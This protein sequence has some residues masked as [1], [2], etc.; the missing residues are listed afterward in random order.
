M[1][2]AQISGLQPRKKGR[3]TIRVPG[4][5]VCE[6]LGADRSLGEDLARALPGLLER[7]EVWSNTTDEQAS[8]L[9]AVGEPSD[10]VIAAAVLGGRFAVLNPVVSLSSAAPS[11]CTRGRTRSAAQTLRPPHA[12]RGA[13]WR[14]RRG[15]TN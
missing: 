8:A 12:R 13:H 10:R 11:T 15:A 7:P 5:R 1:R 4:V 14:E 3:T 2:A 6:D 9:A